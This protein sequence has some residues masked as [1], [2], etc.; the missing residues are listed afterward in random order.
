MQPL[1]SANHV[2]DVHGCDLHV[3][4]FVV[5]LEPAH[6]PSSKAPAPPHNPAI[7][8]VRSTCQ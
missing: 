3:I 5:K 4:P 6:F 1:L 8:D 7:P 2:T